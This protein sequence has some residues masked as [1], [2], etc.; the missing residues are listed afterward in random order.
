MHIPNVF[1]DPSTG[2]TYNWPLNHSSEDSLGKHRN[3]RFSAPTSHEGLLKQ[4]A[5]TEPM[6]LRWKGTILTRAQLRAMIY[7]YQ[8]CE[9]HTIQIT[10]PMDNGFEVLISYFDPVRRAVAFNNKDPENAPYVVWDYT[11]EMLV[12]TIIKGDWVGVTP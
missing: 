7:W 12:V 5:D 3:I 8:K 2:E 11:I 4:Q 6:Y 1:Y 9:D 10:D